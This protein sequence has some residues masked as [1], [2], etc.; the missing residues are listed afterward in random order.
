[1]NIFNRFFLWLVLVPSSLY[2]KM[3]INVNQLRAVLNTKLLIDDR[4]PNTFH[5]TQQKKQKKPVSFATLGTMFVTGFMG[6]FFL[7]SFIVGQDMVTRLTIYFSFFIFILASTLIADFTSVLIDIRDNVVILPKPISD[8]TFVLARLL[9][10]LI[11]ISKLVIPMVL[12]ALI[13]LGIKQP[14]IKLFPFVFL[15]ALATLFTIFLF[16]TLYIFI[17]KITTL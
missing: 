1:M 13:Y 17:L 14:V 5:Q 2:E 7:V 11:H 6:C 16:N 15:I 4:R 10:I 9:H 12:P 3:G 8:K